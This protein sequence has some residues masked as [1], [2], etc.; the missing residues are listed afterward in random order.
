MLRMFSGILVAFLFALCAA[1]CGSSGDLPT[2]P[3]APPVD[4]S[5]VNFPDSKLDGSGGEEDTGS[6]VPGSDDSRPKGP[7]KPAGAN[8]GVL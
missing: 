5:Q 6:V 2:A 3:S 4:P 1:G 7:Q 8:T